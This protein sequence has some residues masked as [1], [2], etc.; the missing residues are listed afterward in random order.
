MYICT[1][2]NT[3]H[4]LDFFIAFQ[5]LYNLLFLRIAWVKTFLWKFD[6]AQLHRELEIL[7]YAPRSV[8]TI[9]VKVMY[10]E[11]H[12]VYGVKGYYRNRKHSYQLKASHKQFE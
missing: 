2:R 11:L 7:F 12:G 1:H 8:K 10:V 9:A 3:V 6:E 5:V 4:H